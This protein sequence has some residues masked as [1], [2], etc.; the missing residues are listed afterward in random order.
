MLL[1]A[2]LDSRIIHVDETKINVQGFNQ[3]VW[4]LTD[5]AHVIFR[6]TETRE[7]TVVQ[8]LLEN[9]RGTLISDFY[10]GYDSISCSHQK[11]LVHLIRD[12]NNDL[13]KNPYN[14]GLEAFIKAFSELITSIMADVQKYGLKKRHLRKHKKTVEAFY[15]NWIDSRT[16]EDEILQR[17]QKRFIRYRDSLFRFLDSDGIPWNNNMAERAI[18]HFAIQRKISGTFYS[19]FAT[20]YLRLLSVAQ[21]CRFQGKSFFAF[22]LSR[23]VDIG[24]FE[25]RKR[26]QISTPV[27]RKTREDQSG[28]AVYLRHAGI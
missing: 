20:P 7:T 1:K 16:Y 11:C 21:S 15:R 12:L 10:G 2:I 22:M 17:Y 28:D 14:I 24:E 19:T 5:G 9:Y 13:W 25:A 18:R 8:E 3:Y 23:K 6:L 26:P 4:V 27:Y